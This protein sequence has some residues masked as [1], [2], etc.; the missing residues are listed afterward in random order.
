MFQNALPALMAEF[1]NSFGQ[2]GLENDMLLH[3]LAEEQPTAEL[4]LCLNKIPAQAKVSLH[5][6]AIVNAFI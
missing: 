1:S 6:V 4:T 5:I 3:L 2:K